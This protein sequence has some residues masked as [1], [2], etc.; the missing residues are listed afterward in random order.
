M[1]DVRTREEGMAELRK[2]MAAMPEPLHDLIEEFPP[3]SRVEAKLGVLLRIP[4]PGVVGEVLTYTDDS[5]LGVRAASAEAYPTTDGGMVPA[6]TILKA[7]VEPT[8][9]HYVGPGGEWEF[10]RLDVKQIRELIGA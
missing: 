1:P 2:W 4:A 7:H 9:M 5:K 6:G 10:T 8:D 3:L